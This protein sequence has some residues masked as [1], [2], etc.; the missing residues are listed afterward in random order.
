MH[1]QEAEV[2]ELPE[3]IARR[4]AGA[5][6]FFKTIPAA[7]SKKTLKGLKVTRRYTAPPTP[8]GIRWSEL[9]DFV[10]RLGAWEP[11]ALQTYADPFP[12][13]MPIA[14]LLSKVM[15]GIRD[16]FGAALV[17]LRAGRSQDQPA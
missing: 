14:S 12:N 6:R 13:R 2:T 10:S 7:F 8:W 1:F 3:E 16:V 9:S 5:E 17:R 11:I 15:P 4:F